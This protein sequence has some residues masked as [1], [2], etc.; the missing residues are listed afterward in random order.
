MRFKA[1]L[2]TSTGIGEIEIEIETEIEVTQNTVKKQEST[3]I[4]QTNFSSCRII[5]SDQNRYK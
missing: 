4:N 2:S 3:D 1:V 5:A